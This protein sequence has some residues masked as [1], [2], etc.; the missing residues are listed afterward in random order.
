MQAHAPRRSPGLLAMLL[1]GLLLWAWWLRPSPPGA[2]AP[3]DAPPAGPAQPSWLWLLPAP[4]PAAPPA[5]PAAATAPAPR[6]PPPTGQPA[7]APAPA[8]RREPGSITLPAVDEPATP[9]PAAPTAA[10]PPAPAA[11]PATAAAAASAASAPLR[12]DLP[13]RSP[14]QAPPWRNPALDDPRSNTRAARSGTL[15]ARIAA[16]LGPGE[17]PVT[18]EALADGGR[19]LRRGSQCVVVRPARAGALDPFN[20][21]VSPKPQTV[22][23]C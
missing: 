9:A 15:E 22:D 7:A 16:A 8:Q 18:E 4:G 12:L 14:G 13:A 3:P 20:N 21:S 2:L 10:A 1:H 17:G 11:A 6:E 23:A 5:P 19:R